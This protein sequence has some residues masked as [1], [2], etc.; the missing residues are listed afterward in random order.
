[1]LIACEH[2]HLCVYTR[3][4]IICIYMHTHKHTH[5]CMSLSWWPRRNKLH[6]CW[7]H[8]SLS[9]CV[10]VWIWPVCVCPVIFDATWFSSSFLYFCPPTRKNLTR[11][12]MCQQAY[13]NTC[14][15]CGSM[16]SRQK[17]PKKIRQARNKNFFFWCLDA[18][19]VDMMVWE[20]LKMC[21]ACN[22]CVSVNILH[23][24]VSTDIT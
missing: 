16:D 14:R 10:R 8:T 9:A 1:M 22:P 23:I 3:G 11:K 18:L 7:L 19:A 4:K 17:F 13:I 12:A 6:A 24:V 21:H 20:H 5:T 15:W 2:V